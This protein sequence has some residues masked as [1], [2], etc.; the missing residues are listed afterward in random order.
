M[1]MLAAEQVAA[2]RAAMLALVPIGVLLLDERG[3][4]IEANPSAPRILGL[5]DAPWNLSELRGRIIDPD[6]GSPISERELPW[7]L[8][9]AGSPVE[10]AQVLV[11]AGRAGS[12]TWPVTVSAHPFRHLGGLEAGAIVVV[13]SPARRTAVQQAQRATLPP[14]LRQVLALLGRGQ[15]TAEIA[16]E[17]SLTPDT[18]RLYIKRIY[19]RLGIRSRA[20]AVLKALELGLVVL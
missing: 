19:A 10:D 5:R 2:R 12:A 14:Y 6:T 15:S 8:A 4:V 13:S 20:Q 3:R 7:H 18:T 17:L 11:R 16:R 1:T 9:L